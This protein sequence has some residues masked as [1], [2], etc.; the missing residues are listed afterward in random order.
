MNICRYCPS[1]VCVP[2]RIFFNKYGRAYNYTDIRISVNTKI[3]M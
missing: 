1:Y 3:R 2:V